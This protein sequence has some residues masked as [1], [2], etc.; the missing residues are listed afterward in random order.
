MDLYCKTCNE[1]LTKVALIH[2]DS[3]GIQTK[4]HAPLLPVAAYVLADELQMEKIKGT[5]YLVS[6]DTLRTVAHQ[7]PIRNSGCCGPAGTFGPNQ[8]CPTCASEI[9]S[10]HADCIGPHFVSV[11]GE[12]VSENPIW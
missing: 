11:I 5:K 2:A 8:V 9:G 7:D 1:R 6:V 10:L 4:D 12:K 3:E